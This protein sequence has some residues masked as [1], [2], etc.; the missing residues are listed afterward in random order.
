MAALATGDFHADHGVFYGGEV[1]W[2]HGPL[3][4]QAEGGV[5]HFDGAGGPSPHFAGWSAQVSW[6]P[7]GEARPYDIKTGVFGRVVPK[8]PLSADGAGAFELGLRV[9]HVD[10][11]DNG[12]AGGELTT[13]GGVVNWYPVTR[14]RL[15]ANLIHSET[16]RPTLAD[17]NQNALTLRGA[18]DW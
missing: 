6:R 11:N 14:V 7:T 15:S 12:L 8:A 5:L 4:V 13:Y 16:E 3:L 17:I 10:L 1:G 18:I 2:S 9:S